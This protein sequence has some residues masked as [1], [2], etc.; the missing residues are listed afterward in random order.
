M[1]SHEN[2]TVANYN[3]GQKSVRFSKTSW[4]GGRAYPSIPMPTHLQLSIL[5]I[6]VHLK[7]KVMEMHPEYI[8]WIGNGEDD[9]RRL[10]M[11]IV[12]AWDALPKSL[13][14]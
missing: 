14:V 6:W 12:E 5:R 10:E 9:I 11:A 3:A 2:H 4:H 7:R 1:P 13:F 8:E